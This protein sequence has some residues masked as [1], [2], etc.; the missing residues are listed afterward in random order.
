M[1]KNQAASHVARVLSAIREQASRNDSQLLADSITLSWKRCIDHYRLDPTQMHEK[2]VIEHG[3]LVEHQER[4]SNI[5]EIA[6][7]EMNN[8][9][10]QIAGSGFAILLTDSQGVILNCISDPTL[11][12]SF[13]RAGLWTG[14]VWNEE[15][16]GTNA[17][18]TCLMEKQPL[19]VHRD[20]HF[21]SCNIGLTCSASPIFDPYGNLLAILDV[22]SVNS[23]DSKQSQFHTMALAVMAAKLIENCN[24]L[25]QFR[26]QWVVRFHNRPEFV[27]L[28]SEGMLA[29]NGE[30]RIL[31]ANQSALNQLGCQ[32][33]KQLIGRLVGD[34]FNIRLDTLMERAS[35]QSHTLC[36]PA[37]DRHGHDYFAMLLGP[38]HRP[39]VG[40]MVSRDMIDP[41]NTAMSMT[42]EGLKGSDPLMAYNVRCIQRVMNK[43]VTI[44]LNGET[45]T[46]KEAIAKAVH[47]A[48]NRPDKPFVAV[49]CASIPEN[50]IES[51]LFGYKH[52]AFT[53]ARREGMRG[54]IL[55]S[56]GGTLFL[57]EIG[58][59][60]PQ[61]QTRLLRVL[62]EKEVLPLGCEKGIPIDLHVIS[63]THRDLQKLVEDGCFREDLYYRLNGL[64]LTL[65][66][67]RER[68]DQ[69]ALIR[70]ILA[71]ES[72]GE[73]VQL[74]EAA[75]KALTNYHWPGNIRQLRNV[76]RTAIAL[77][78]EG[79]IQLEDLPPEIAW[80]GASKTPIKRLYLPNIP[81]RDDRTALECAE[82]EA[83][84]REL[85][86]HHWNI[87][88][89]SAHLGIS[90]NTLYRK[91][92]KH[93]INPPTL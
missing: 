28:L 31:A 49:N 92:K 53:G 34:I 42:L 79:L 36:W 4:L 66:A 90:R 39:L 24:F 57:D 8:L 78:E 7:T 19:T 63:A 65:P 61:L 72:G 47:Q 38:E 11:A 93:G 70:C 5:L 55:Q 30:G 83:L 51:E 21:L 1:L 25:Q 56:S 77:C 84:L 48:S 68:T 23:Q 44:L 67:L 13:M 32:A 76:L 60:P 3:T 40:S 45:G 37:H 2:F 35:R 54:K 58:D 71:A 59:M 89:T 29:F 75:F 74:D 22:S 64:T 50:L 9:Y 6:R 10:Q 91:M 20:E 88:N 46:G 33:H 41:A 27:G 62:E 17:I 85:D 82:K 18:G 80:R 87:T 15:H 16:E 26:A 12:K 69:V 52:G 86:T 14:A 73:P 81:T 43:N